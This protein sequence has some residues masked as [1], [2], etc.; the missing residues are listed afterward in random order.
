MIVGEVSP[1]REALIRVVVL[2]PGG[3]REKIEAA[4]DTGFTGALSLPL[5][6]VQRL[7]LP[8]REWIVAVLA[9]GSEIKLGSHDAAVL[10]NKRR[11]KIMVDATDAAPLVGM[12]LLENHELKIQVRD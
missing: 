2:G 1:E 9:D 11:L 8:W 12:K 4:I 3:R 6:V 10:W 7:E 5:A